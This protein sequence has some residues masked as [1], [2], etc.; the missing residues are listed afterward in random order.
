MTAVSAEVSDAP[1]VASRNRDVPEVGQLVKVRGQQWV[2][3]RRQHQSPA[4]RRARRD[5]AARP[6]PRHPHQR[7]RRRP[8]RRADR[9]L[10]GRARPRDR[11][12]HPAAGGDA[13][14]LGRP[15]A[16]GRLPRTPSA[17]APWPAPTP[18]RSR[19]RSGPASRSRS[20]SSNPSPAPSP[21][22]GSTCSSPTTWASARRSRPAWSSRRCCCGTGHGASSSSARRR[23]RSSGT[24]RWRPSSASASRSWTPP[25]SGSSG[26]PTGSKPTPSPSTR[27]RSSACNGCAPPA[28]SACWMRS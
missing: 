4:S 7:Q 9:R 16:T 15:A 1:G 2:V 10:G 3:S 5:Q 12:R 25:S 17:G 27:A 21:C 28:S 22:R 23:S 26:D 19:P 13:S 6:Y 20:T 14:E 11:P 8:R 18:G 24:R